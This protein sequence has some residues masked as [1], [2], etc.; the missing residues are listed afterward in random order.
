MSG[1]TQLR[2]PLQP[3]P[4]AGGTGSGTSGGTA[5]SVVLSG[6]VLHY[7]FVRARRRTIGI[8]VR[9][10]QVEARAPRQAVLAEVEAFLRQ[11]E[12]WITKRLTESTPEPRPFRWNEGETL[13]VLGRPVRLTAAAGAGMVRLADDC[14]ELPPAVPAR[15]REL[16]VEWLH[17]T[18]LDLFRKRIPHYAALL[19]VG[20]P[21]LGLSNAQTQWGSCRRTRGEAGRVLLNWRLVHLPPTLI[22]YVVAHELAHL[23]EH[24]HSPRFWAIVAQLFPDYL[25]ARRELKR[26]GRA[27]PRL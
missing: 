9:R 20:E 27:L 19:G 3:V 15:W 23:R 21:A 17:G 11:K 5:R 8:V 25:S 7:R 24:N 6:G 10:G 26:L 1:L 12:R 16:T 18:A 2:L 13:P 14:L 22:D 4:E